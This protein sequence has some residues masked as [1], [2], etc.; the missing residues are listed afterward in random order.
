LEIVP[1]AAFFCARS[2][3]DPRKNFEP[4][5]HKDTK[6]TFSLEIVPVA[7]FFRA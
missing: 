5:R 6:V 7:A 2:A 4:Q 3:R 1:V